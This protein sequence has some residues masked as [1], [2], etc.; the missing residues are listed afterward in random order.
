MN[1]LNQKAAKNLTPNNSSHGTKVAAD[2]AAAADEAAPPK[3]AVDGH[4]KEELLA[5]L[6]KMNKKVKALS[7]LRQ[8]LTE[9]AETAEIWGFAN[10]YSSE[11]AADI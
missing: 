4:S 2:M 6:Q 10:P 8:Q 7:A 5:V 11:S 1:E 9:R 3:S